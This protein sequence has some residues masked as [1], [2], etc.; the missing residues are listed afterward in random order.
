MVLPYWSPNQHTLGA[1]LQSAALCY[2]LGTDQHPRQEY[3]RVKPGSNDHQEGPLLTSPFFISSEHWV[4]N[5]ARNLRHVLR[6]QPHR[7]EDF[8]AGL[9]MLVD[10]DTGGFLHFS[11]RSSLS[12]DLLEEAEIALVYQQGNDF[13]PDLWDYLSMGNLPDSTAQ[14]VTH[15]WQWQAAQP[16]LLGGPIKYPQ[17]PRVV[18]WWSTNLILVLALERV[19]QEEGQALIDQH[20]RARRLRTAQQLAIFSCTQATTPQWA[21]VYLKQQCK[22]Y[23]FT[24]PPTADQ[25]QYRGTLLQAVLRLTVL[26]C[27]QRQLPRVLGIFRKHTLSMIAFPEPPVHQPARFQTPEDSQPPMQPDNAA[28]PST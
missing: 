10:P 22:Q 12:S 1:L 27:S 21:Q 6:Y 20:I 24:P 5:T 9:H 16:D 2:E 15:R 23:E 26:A 8:E 19:V 28:G 7:E 14:Q 3:F 18:T 13:D 17:A 25:S 11:D 4:D